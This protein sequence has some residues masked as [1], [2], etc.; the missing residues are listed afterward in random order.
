MA[1]PPSSTTK[2]KICFKRKLLA[3]EFSCDY[4]SQMYILERSNSTSQ[5]Q[6]N[7]KTQKTPA[8]EWTHL[9]LHSQ[10]VCHV[11]QQGDGG[12]VLT[13]KHQ[14]QVQVPL[15]QQALGHQAH[16]HHPTQDTLWRGSHLTGTGEGVPRKCLF[17]DKCNK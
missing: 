14:L 9:E 8:G 6:L 16:P 7:M 1:I 13:Q 4:S 3:T 10:V 15:Q 12:F 11:L 17:R 5:S 2:L